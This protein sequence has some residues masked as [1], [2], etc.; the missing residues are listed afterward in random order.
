LTAEDSLLLNEAYTDAEIF[1]YEKDLLELARRGAIDLNV[2]TTDSVQ[3]WRWRNILQLNTGENYRF[4]IRTFERP[5]ARPIF[6]GYD[7]VHN[8]AIITYQ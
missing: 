6:L 8:E 3:Y 1:V 4:T 2:T 5:W 7:N